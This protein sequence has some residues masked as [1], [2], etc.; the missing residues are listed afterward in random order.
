[1]LVAALAGAALT[2]RL[3]FWQ[4]DRAA[5]KEALQAA[6]D[7]RAGCRRSV[8]PTWRRA[9]RL[10][11]DLLYRQVAL[12]GRWLAERTVYLDNRQMNARPG[13]IVVTP[14]QWPAAARCSC[15]AAGSRATT[16]TAPAC[17]RLPTPAGEVEVTGRIAPPPS[18]LY[19]FGGGG[20]GADPAESGPRRVRARDR[21]ALLPVSVLQADA[22]D[23][24]DGDGLLRNGRARR[25][26]STSTTA[27]RSSGW[28]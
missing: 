27:M 18:R 26:T 6:L 10:R 16:T 28:R 9:G 8:R 1:M 11:P 12:R 25:S 5:Q 22:A 19:E 21:P 13:F 24:A 20:V 4:W 2:A 17:P 3:G 7:A 23:A 14:L 15:S